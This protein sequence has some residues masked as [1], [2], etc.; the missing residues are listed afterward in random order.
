[1]SD[2]EELR[3]DQEALRAEL[4]QSRSRLD[5]LV[6]EL[7]SIDGMLDEMAVER[8]QYALVREACG[9][10]EKLSEIGGASLF[11]GDQPAERN[12]DSHVGDVRRR[13]D[14]FEAQVR[15]VEQSRNA[16]LERMRGEEET[17]EYIEFDIDEA[18]REE[19]QRKLEWLI[20][21]DYDPSAETEPRMPWASG[22]EDDRRFHKS[23]SGAL[24][25]A[26]LLALV[27]PMIDL[28]VPERWEVVEV[29]ERFTRLI[30]EEPP[31]PPPV[32]QERV[33]EELKPEV[34]E[35]QP[36]LAEK[37]APETAPEPAPKTKPQTK[38][39]AKGILAFREK[40]SNLAEARPAARL[41]ARARI[42]QSGEAAVGDRGRSLV[43][44]QAPGSSGGIDVASLSRDAVGGG[45][46][47][48]EGV[49]VGRAESSI[50]GITGPER[51]LSGGPGAGRTD[52]EI[53]IVFDRHKA[54]LYRLYNRALRRDPTLQGQIVLRITV[55]PDGSVSLSEVQSSDMKAPKLGAQVAARVKNF[56][57]G[58][59]EGIPP[60]TILYPIDFLPAT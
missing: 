20:E 15:D 42:D 34:S 38:P 30:K 37:K 50:G 5:G 8:Q 18:K 4:D 24:L 53:Q 27:V 25:I 40:F 48:I 60:V 11:W 52:E 39:A 22:G 41:G 31:P 23:L 13:V 49:Q 21:R 2:N 35:D 33:P 57:F 1:M 28:P 43:T 16:V 56:D 58:A 36:V 26:M 3:Q 55:E 10:L 45:G 9:V 12:G 19:E 44:T 29:S 46:Q 51:P 54:A 47:A 14:Q 59:K 32:V 6:R 7:G 17:A